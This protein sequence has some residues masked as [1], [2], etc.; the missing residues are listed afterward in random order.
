MSRTYDPSLLLPINPSDLACAR[1]WV[2]LWLRNNPDAQGKYPEHDLQDSEYEAA[3]TLDAV[4][5][6]VVWY[7]RPALTAAR[8]Y[9]G[10]PLLLKSEGAEGWSNSR[11]D[12][13]EIVAAWLGQGAAFDRLI[14]VGLL[15]A[16]AGIGQP[17]TY[18]PRSAHRR[19]VL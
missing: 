15:P 4:T 8:L 5:D 10:D 19:T 11:R 9:E 7:Y 3:L 1:T 13:A 12:T 14:P 2:R 6:G 18:P 16:T 17:V